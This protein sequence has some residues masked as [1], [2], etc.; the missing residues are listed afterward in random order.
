MKRR[1]E[2]IKKIMKE[3][4]MTLIEASREIKAKKMTY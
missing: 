4:G 3:K 1:G 2:L